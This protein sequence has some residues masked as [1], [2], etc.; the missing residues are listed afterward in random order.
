M[1]LTSALGS[2]G[3]F[4]AMTAQNPALVKSLGQVEFIFTLLITTLFFKEK[5]TGRE[6]FGVLA[7]VASVI[8]IIKAT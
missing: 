4:T 2:I 6:L 8:L 7:I 3:W 1:G 5:V